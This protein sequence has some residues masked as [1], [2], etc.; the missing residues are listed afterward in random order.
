MGRQSKTPKE[1]VDNV[2]QA[3]NTFMDVEP[4]FDDTTMMAVRYFGSDGNGD[5]STNPAQ[6]D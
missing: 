5:E 6:S 4:R 2:N 1:I 3:I